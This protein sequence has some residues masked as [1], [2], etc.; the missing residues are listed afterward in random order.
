MRSL[1][2]RAQPLVSVYVRVGVPASLVTWSRLRSGTTGTHDKHAHIS[3]PLSVSSINQNQILSPPLRTWQGKKTEVLARKKKEH[4]K[5][6]PH[7][8]LLVLSI[9][10]PAESTGPATPS[11][12]QPSVEARYFKNKATRVHEVYD[13]CPT[14][15][16]ARSGQ[17]TAPAVSCFDSGSSR[18]SHASPAHYPA[19]A[20]ATPSCLARSRP[21][22]SFRQ[23]TM[24]TF[25]SLP[26]P[27]TCLD[28][29]Q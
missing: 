13:V 11:Q 15:G 14:C 9:P 2:F 19:L 23:Q 29:T 10:P 6:H 5:E 28:R 27:L 7:R 8:L 16:A 1:V 25:A 12:P 17:P 26:K 21:L 22:P 24:H 18:L 20:S 4:R 3:V